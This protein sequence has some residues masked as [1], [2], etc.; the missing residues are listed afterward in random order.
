MFTNEI[1]H[2]ESVITILDDGGF[3]EDVQVYLYEDIVIIRQW[4]EDSESFKEVG[5]SPEMF[6]QFQI[7][8]NSPVGAF[9]IK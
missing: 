3:Y 5:M 2:D 1:D 4:D 6:E 7:A 8:L 9:R